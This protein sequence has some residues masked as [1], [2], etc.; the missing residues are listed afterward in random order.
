MAISETNLTKCSA[1][2]DPRAKP[3][4][5][6]RA[7]QGNGDGDNTAVTAGIPRFCLWNFW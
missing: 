6:I 2:I 4:I 1:W 3:L 5:W 7:L